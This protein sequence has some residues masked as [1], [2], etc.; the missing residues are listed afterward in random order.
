[1]IK[2][3]VGK[4]DHLPENSSSQI[5]ARGGAHPGRHESN[6]D[7]GRHPE[8]RKAGHLPAGGHQVADLESVHIDPQILI[9][10]SHKTYRRLIEDRIRQFRSHLLHTGNKRLPLFFRHHLKDIEYGHIIRSHAVRQRGLQLLFNLCGHLASGLESGGQ[11]HRA[12]QHI[13]ELCHVFIGHACFYHI[14]RHI[15]D[16]LIFHITVKN[17]LLFIRRDKQKQPVHLFHGDLFRH[18]V[19][20]AALLDAHID[21]VR[22]VGRQRQITVRLDKQHGDDQ[23]ER[24]PVLRRI[25]K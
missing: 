20:H 4:S 16:I 14:S 15:I 3:I 7:A 2:L 21:D 22:R 5:P 6:Q 13:P 24:L 23:K 9:G 1:M 19:L 18:L 10:I 8:E 25:L 12:R 11:H 17:G